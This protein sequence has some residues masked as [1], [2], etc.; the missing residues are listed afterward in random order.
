MLSIIVPFYNCMEYTSLCVESV[1]DNTTDFEIILI[2]N[3][4]NEKEY[5]SFYDNMLWKEQNNSISFSNVR[6]IKNETNLGFPKA[7]NQGLM[8]SKGDIICVLNNDVVVTPGW[9]NNLMW[10]LDNGVDIVSPRTNFID[11]PQIVLIDRYDNKGELYSAA[12][13]FHKNNLHKKWRFSRLVGFCLLFKRG[14]Y[15]AIG[16]F[17]EGFGIG[18]FEDDDWGLRAIDAGY[19]CA[20]ARDVYV[21]HFGSKTHE[22]MKLDYKQLLS[23]NRKIFESIWT[24]DKIKQLEQKNEE[25]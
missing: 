23:V 19:K 17:N 2:D 20:I 6:V 10:H 11:G 4:S 7:V 18:N 8:E 9:A 1:C 16:G 3:G 22:I 12:R 21:H 14:V 24:R 5:D 25:D 15:E 13:K